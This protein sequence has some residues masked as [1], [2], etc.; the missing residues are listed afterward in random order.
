MPTNGHALAVGHDLLQTTAL[1][2]KHATA[3]LFRLSLHPDLAG[4]AIDIA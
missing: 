3:V 2:E 1:Y 4:D